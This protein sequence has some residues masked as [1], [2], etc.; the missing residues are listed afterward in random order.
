MGPIVW[1]VIGTGAAVMAATVARNV[2]EKGWRAAFG[3]NPPVNP[4]SPD[5]EWMEALLWAVVSGAL[6]GTAR[7][8]ATRQAAH[9]YQKSAGH[10]P[11][12]LESV[13]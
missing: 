2:L 12:G 6:I 8:L 3:K 5:T 11:K 7:M 1:K 13:Q 9:Y 4:E 10:L